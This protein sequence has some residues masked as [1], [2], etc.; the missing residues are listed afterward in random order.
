MSWR[1]QLQPA[2]FRGVEFHAVQRSGTFGRRNQ[3]HEYPFRDLPYVEDLG[4]MARSFRIS[5]FLIG[6]DCLRQRDALIAAIEQPGPGKLVHPTHG[7]MNVSV[8]GGVVL[9]ESDLEAG[10]VRIT[11][12]VTE[13]GELRFPSAD[14]ATQDVVARRA[15]TAGAALKAAT[16]RKLNTRDLPAFAEN[17]AVGRAQRVLDTVQKA[18]ALVTTRDK[19]G[20]LLSAIA[21]LQPDLAASL[22][23]PIDFATRAYSLLEGLFNGLRGDDR[24]AVLDSL[25][26]FGRAEAQW[27]AFTTTR[28]R[29]A[30]NRSA[31][32]ELVRGAAAI[33]EARTAALTEFNDYQG[34]TMLRDRVVDRIDGVADTTNDDVLFSALANLRAAV[35]RDINARGADLARV[36]TLTPPRTLPALVLAYGLYEDAGRDAELVQRNR[37][38]HPGFVPAHQPLEVAIDG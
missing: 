4:R 23:T 21:L 2:S 29:D 9:D 25:A 12:N 35:V 28:R 6:P 37:I 36:A 38:Q 13:S 5:G 19:R 18:A 22:R 14:A 31:I 30:A 16:A 10:A 26:D 20:A 24:D 8:V 17:L 7:E 34:A 32:E 3:V 1:D 15:D 11:F 27:P 33:A